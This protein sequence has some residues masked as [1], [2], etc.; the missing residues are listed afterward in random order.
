[1]CF[2]KKKSA[3]FAF[4]VPSVCLLLANNGSITIEQFANGC[5]WLTTA[6][7]SS[8]GI[9]LDR[10]LDLLASTVMANRRDF[11][12]IASGVHDVAR[13]TKRLAEEAGVVLEN[14]HAEVD[15]AKENYSWIMTMH[16]VI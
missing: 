4:C 8:D 1:M 16:Q 14:P 3:Y 15:F 11:K 7:K 2:N 12:Q 13:T 5:Q 6:A 9:V 10:K